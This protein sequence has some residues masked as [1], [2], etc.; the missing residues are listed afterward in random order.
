MSDSTPS[1]VGCTETTVR[2]YKVTDACGNFINVTQNLI[3]TVD[4]T[5]PTAS[6]PAAITLTGCNGT[7]PAADVSVVTDETDNCS[8]PTVT[9]VSD[10]TPNIVG[11]TETTIR[12]YKVTDACGNFI[13]VTQNLIRTVDTTKPTASN[14]AAITLTGCNGT[15]PAADVSVVTDEADACSTPTVT[16]V[17]DS[18]PSIVGCTETTVR[19]YKVT[20]ACG[21]F[22]NVTQNLIRTVDTTNPTASNPAAITLTGCNGTFPAANVS[23][24][25]D[26]ADA[27]STPTVTFVSDSTPS[28]VGCT[29]TTVRTYKVT[30]ACGNFIN[31]TQN[32]IRT[33]DTTKPTASNPA[34]ITLTGCNGTFPAANVSVVTDEADACSTPTVTFVSDST[35]SIVGC[36]ETTVRT[37]K[38]TDACG[39][40]INVT[41]NLIRTVDTTKPTASNPAAITLTGCNGTFPAADVSV[42]TDETDN[43]STPTVTFVS[44]STPNIVGCTET[45]IRTYKVTDACGNFINVTQNLIRTVDTTKPT[46]SNPA[47]ITLTGCNGTFPAANVSVVTDEA[48]A[49]STP[50]VTF[51]SDSAP[52]IVGCTETTVRTYKVTDACGNSINVTQNLIRTVDTT[53]PTFTVPKDVEIFTSAD[54]SYDDSVAKTGDVTNEADNCSAELNATYTDAE[55][56]AGS[57]P[58]SKTIKRTWSLVDACGNKADDQ[59]QT[60]T[61]NR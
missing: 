33:V 34:A 7:F 35:P 50:T 15:F 40:F 24:V 2:T 45:T 30:D 47:A 53:K 1:I 21:N 38:V 17:S 20:D 23:V 9:F 26:E 8:T 36:T 10:S 3:R 31:V 52:S 22:I 13:N 51:V 25:T 32:L 19:T 60:I 41:Q 4:T 54:C 37:Y 44:D 5:K 16:F 11:C 48:D 55:P 61:V 42:V 28:I 46:A 6:N 43:C 12:T 29:E 57:C 58:G 27:C 14:P 59:I 39:N 56:I 18:A 49:C